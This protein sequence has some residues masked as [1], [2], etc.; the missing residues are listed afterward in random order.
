MTQNELSKLTDQELL[1]QAKK[2]KSA[3]IASALLIGFMIGVVVWSVVQNTVGLFTLIP[4]FFIY[5]LINNKK[6]KESNEAL[7]KV[8]QERKLD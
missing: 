7:K 2:V 1:E 3:A 4:L 5:K 6:N 8:L